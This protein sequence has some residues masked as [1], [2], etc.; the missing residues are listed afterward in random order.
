MYWP[1]RGVQILSSE[2]GERREGFEHGSGESRLPAHKGFCPPLG[3]ARFRVTDRVFERGN[4]AQ[5]T[6]CEQVVVLSR[7]VLDG[8]R[9]GRTGRRGSGTYHVG[10]SGD[11]AGCGNSA[12]CAMPRRSQNCFVSLPF[13]FLK[14]MLFKS[15]PS[16]AP[17]AN[18]PRG[19]DSVFIILK[20]KNTQEKRHTKHRSSRLPCALTGTCSPFVTAA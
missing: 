16:C 17:K 10:E 6:V 20:L 3:S 5:R 9:S 15:S 12:V 4:W 13:V 2:E 11:G 8:P 18:A 19:L 1:S 7:G 14:D